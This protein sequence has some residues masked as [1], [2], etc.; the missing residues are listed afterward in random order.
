MEFLQ[1][2][3]STAWEGLKS[4][5][6][7]VGNFFAHPIDTTTGAWNGLFG[8]NTPD[9]GS[10]QYNIANNQ[11]YG[12]SYSAGPEMRPYSGIDHRTEPANTAQTENAFNRAA[13]HNGVFSTGNPQI[14][15]SMEQGAYRIG[16]STRHVFNTAASIPERVIN[17]IGHEASRRASIGIR[18]S[19]N[20][21]FHR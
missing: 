18:Q 5:A 7:S 11:N 1:N 2:V 16:G 15:R 21:F 13:T 17:G 8:N 14:D 20:G 19:M 3:M 4:F 12:N 6:E 9:G 10:Q